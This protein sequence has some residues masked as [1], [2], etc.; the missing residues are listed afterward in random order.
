MMWALLTGVIAGIGVDSRRLPALPFHIPLSVGL[1][2]MGTQ[3]QPAVISSVGLSGVGLAFLVI[4]TT[5]LAFIAM[6][7]LGL[8]P[9]RL[10][11]LLALG[12]SGCGISAIAAAAQSDSKARAS[13]VSISSLAVLVTGAVS[14][15]LLPLSAGWIGLGG[16]TFGL[17]AGLTVANT[18]EAVAVAQTAGNESMGVAASV[19][20]AVNALQGVAIAV[21]L[22]RFAP[23]SPGRL[24]MKIFG[25]VPVFVWGFVVLAV[26][27]WLGGFSVS[28]RSS[29]GNLTSWAFFIAL[30]GV[31][32]QTRL[33]VLRRIGIRPLFLASLVWLGVTALIILALS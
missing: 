22:W 4:G 20:L 19:K 29:L 15:V 24:P 26:A 8:L 9:A 6:A 27:A 25:R 30:V 21:Y 28:E 7:R 12:M 1:I 23:K 13:Q 33:Q 11:G 16:R 14:L 5:T 32:F 17:L 10:A 18:A 3:V 31:G 2:L